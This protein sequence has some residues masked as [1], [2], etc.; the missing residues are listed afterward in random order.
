M[1]SGRSCKVGYEDTLPRLTIMIMVFLKKNFHKILISKTS[2]KCDSHLQRSCAEQV[3]L[4]SG[5]AARPAEVHMKS[6][7]ASKNQD[8]CLMAEMNLNQVQSAVIVVPVFHDKTKVCIAHAHKS[9]LNKR[10]P[11]S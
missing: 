8:C 5:S 1:V 4:I 6:Y 9:P 2:N 3:N 7:F 11:C 10:R